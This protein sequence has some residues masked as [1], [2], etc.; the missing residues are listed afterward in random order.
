MDDGR[1]PGNELLD[2]MNLG[3]SSENGDATVTEP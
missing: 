2:S 1:A 3:A